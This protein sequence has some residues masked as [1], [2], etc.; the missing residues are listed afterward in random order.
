MAEQSLIDVL[1]VWDEAVKLFTDEKWSEAA[2]KFE[3]ISVKSSRI[4]FNIGSCHLAL[5]RYQ[6]AIQVRSSIIYWFF[7]PKF[8]PGSLHW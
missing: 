4:L 3:K 1:N 8:K 2:A 5:G 6:E 7:F